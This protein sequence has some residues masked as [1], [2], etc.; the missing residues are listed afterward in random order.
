MVI[1]LAVWY[2]HPGRPE[3]VLG[4]EAALRPEDAAKAV[5]PLAIHQKG[6]LHEVVVALELRRAE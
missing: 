1:E 5:P 6:G 4:L 3:G 2:Q